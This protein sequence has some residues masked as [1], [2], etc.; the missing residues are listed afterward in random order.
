METGDPDTRE[1]RPSKPWWV[2]TIVFSFSTTVILSVMLGVTG[3]PTTEWPFVAGI[4]GIVLFLSSV[5]VSVVL[6]VTAKLLTSYRR[7]VYEES[8]LEIEVEDAKVTAHVGIALTIRLVLTLL[9]AGAVWGMALL[10]A[11]VI[12]GGL[13]LPPFVSGVHVAAI[14]L[15]VVG[16]GGLA[17][18]IGLSFVGY[19]LIGRMAKGAQT[20]PWVVRLVWNVVHVA[21]RGTQAGSLGGASVRVR[22]G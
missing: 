14:A 10:V 1:K 12:L 16:G 22:V 13:G 9:Y 6:L 21:Q 19:F 17:A 20:A 4:V 8:G 7:T 18:L 11:L 2:K 15:V 3:Y 5:A